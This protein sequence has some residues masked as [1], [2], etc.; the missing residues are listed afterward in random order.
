MHALRRHVDTGLMTTTP[1]LDDSSLYV[2]LGGEA[3]VAALVD[4]FYER[5]LAD[6][7]L[8]HTSTAW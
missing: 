5:V 8:A 3:A 7:D 1:L 2:R 4:G 6:A